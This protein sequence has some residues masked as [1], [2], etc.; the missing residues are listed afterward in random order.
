[1]INSTQAFNAA[2]I[3]MN[4]GFDF[5]S[6]LLQCSLLIGDASKC[7]ADLVVLPENFSM[8]SAVDF[9]DLATDTKRQQYLF[10]FLSSQARKYQI[11][12]V[13]GTIPLIAL[14][15]G[16]VF[17]TCQVFNSEGNLVSSYQKIHLFDVDVADDVK[18]YRE[19]ESIQPGNNWVVVDMNGIRLA[20]AICYDLRFPE[21]FRAMS[22]QGCDLIVLPSAFTYVTG[23][24]HWEA[25]LRARA[26]ENQCYVLA[27]NQTGEH[28]GRKGVRRQTYG[29]SMIVD[30]QGKILGVLPEG[31]GSIV[32]EID[33]SKQNAL[34]KS[35]PV[36]EHRK[37]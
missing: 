20:L 36:L 30:Y 28:I 22:K 12:L 6:N 19:S 3:Q 11:W 33:L 26:I 9:Y 18:S 23:R 21:L 35:M 17:S 32:T 31:V 25:L 7:G 10:D 4:S 8:F 24:M 16:K 13:A 34:R 1:M 2:V 29:H 15:K 14:D 5:E 27:A 37:L